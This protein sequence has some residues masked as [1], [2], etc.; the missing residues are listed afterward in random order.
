ME[1]R[2]DTFESGWR[3]QA[4]EKRDEEMGMLGRELLGLPLH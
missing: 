4:L 1:E 2:D 3:S